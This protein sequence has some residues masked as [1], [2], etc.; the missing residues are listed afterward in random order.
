MMRIALFGATGGTGHQFIRQA[1]STGLR[2][3]RSERVPAKKLVT[4]LTAPKARMNVA[5]GVANGH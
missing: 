5:A 2:P 3:Y 1:T 4:A